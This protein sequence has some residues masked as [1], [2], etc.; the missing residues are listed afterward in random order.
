MAR[1]HVDWLRRNSCTMKR[2]RL[3]IDVREGH[4]VV[5]A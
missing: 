4:K 1:A 3:L 5:A 2:D